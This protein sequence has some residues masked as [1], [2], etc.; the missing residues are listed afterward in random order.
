MKI[1]I[2]KKR[3]IESAQF[4]ETHSG[5]KHT[6]THTHT[7]ALLS[8]SIQGSL[9]HTPSPPQTLGLMF[10]QSA[11]TVV[12]LPKSQERDPGLLPWSWG[13]RWRHQPPWP[14]GGRVTQRGVPWVGWG[15]WL[16]EGVSGKEEVTEPEDHTKVL[17]Q[18]ALPP[19]KL[20]HPS[21]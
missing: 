16:L 5:N 11:D 8:G 13:L 20:A 6:H 21:P 18:E 1:Y 19:P 9:L 10:T 2:F 15:W 4:N 14:P 12:L 17:L 7:Q 3:D